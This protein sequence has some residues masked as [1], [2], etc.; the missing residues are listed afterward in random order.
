MAAKRACEWNKFKEQ[1]KNKRTKKQP[2]AKVAPGK[3][4]I[5]EREELTVQQLSAAVSGK[6]QKYETLRR[7]YN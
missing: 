7:T 6:A 5:L 2:T 3:A 4:S 1:M